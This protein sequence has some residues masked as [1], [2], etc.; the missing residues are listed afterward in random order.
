[1]AIVDSV[2][3]FTQH[4]DS[5]DSTSVLKNLLIGQRINTYAKLAFAIGSPQKPPAEDE[6]SNF[7]TTL[8]GGTDL[9]IGEM[10]DVKRMHFESVTIVIANLKSRVTADTG[11]EGVRKIPNAEKQ[12]RLAEEACRS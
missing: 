6:F 7:C 10:T 9:T 12:A 4:C 2:A 1:M 8:N 5:I 11:V 3:S